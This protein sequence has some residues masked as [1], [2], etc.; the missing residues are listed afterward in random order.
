MDVWHSDTPEMIGADYP[1][2]FTIEASGEGASQPSWIEVSFTGVEERCQ[3]KLRTTVS[4]P[5]IAAPDL[6][7]APYGMYIFTWIL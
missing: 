4:L 3:D 1:P 2:R 5:L 7:V 6:E